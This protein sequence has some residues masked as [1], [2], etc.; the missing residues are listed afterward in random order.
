MAV[1]VAA[2]FVPSAFFPLFFLLLLLPP[3]LPSTT[4]RF[5]VAPSA[6]L[7]PPPPLPPLLLAPA[8]DFLRGAAGVAGAA[9]ASGAVVAA[10]GG[11]RAAGDGAG[12]AAAAT[13]ASTFFAGA[14]V[15]GLRAL[16]VAARPVPPAVLFRFVLAEGEG[17]GG[18][19]VSVLPVVGLLSD[20][21]AF[22]LLLRRRGEERI[23]GAFVQRW[24]GFGRGGMGLKRKKRRELLERDGWNGDQEKVRQEV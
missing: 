13:G 5:A 9:G 20:A 6:A 12:G 15:S 3:T 23:A 11:R 16:V 8:A 24:R 21:L 19:L 22:S 18:V 1:F 2:A 4:F 7:P 17:A 10:A 14:D